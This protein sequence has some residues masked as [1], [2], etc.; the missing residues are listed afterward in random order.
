MQ[1]DQITTQLRIRTTFESIDLGFVMARKWFIPLW[2]LWVII[3]LPVFILSAFFFHT[4]DSEWIGLFIIWWLKPLYEPALTFWLSRTLFSEQI[5]LKQVMKQWFK[6]IIKPLFFSS[7]LWH[8]FN[9]NR[10]FYYPLVL[11]E[12]QKGEAKS[13]RAAVLGHGQNSFW[14]TWICFVFEFVI[15]ISCYF[16][17]L[18]MMPE[19]MVDRFLNDELYSVDIG[20][21]LDYA[22]LFIA[23]SLIAPFYLAAGFSLYINRRTKLEA[24]DLE[25]KFKNMQNRLKQS[26]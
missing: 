8:R 26:S 18:I 7:L 4:K 23:M 15:F 17:I 21:I 20:I 14:L 19:T 10:S 6:V 16:F 2:K 9:F 13:R 5:S 11:L 12:Q 22:I 25:I 1:L 3:A 24:W